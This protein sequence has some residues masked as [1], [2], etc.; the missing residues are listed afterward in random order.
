M[1]R[2]ARATAPAKV[3]LLGEH[4]VVHGCRAL[5]TAIDLRAEVTCIRVEGKAI[6]LRSGKLFCIRR[7]DGGVD[8][9]ERSWKTLKP[10]LSLVDELLSEYV[11]NAIGVRVEID[12]R[13][14]KGAGLGSSAAV[15]VALAKALSSLLEV[16]LSNE[17][18]KRMAMKPEQEIHGMPSGID[19]H[20]TTY[21]GI[22]VFQRPNSWEELEQNPMKLIIINSGRRRR[23][24]KLVERFRNFTEAYPELFYDMRSLYDR[25]FEE[26]LSSYL[27]GDLETLGRLMAV[28]GFMLRLAGVSTP[29]LD[30]IVEASMEKNIYGA[31]LTGAGGG[32]CV[33][34]LPKQDEASRVA[35]ELRQRFQRVWVSECPREGVRVEETL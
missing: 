1:K 22:L 13:I 3:I 21:G 33:I 9:D 28:N 16:E 34:A 17:E 35:E 18:L 30:R 14:P 5:V 29:E 19:P 31:K 32:G 6:E 4:F 24:G 26:A 2:L 25:L 11:S 12:S 8:A 7:P 10:F 20:I 27:A 15:S 23:T